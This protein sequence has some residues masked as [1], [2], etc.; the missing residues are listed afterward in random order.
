MGRSKS[1]VVGYRYFFGIHMGIGRGPVDE[2]HEVKVGERTAWRGKVSSNE[3]INIDA[4]NLFGGEE[5][6]GGVQGPLEVMM[7]G[8]DQVASPGLAAMLPGPLSGFRR[9]F[10][11]FYDGLVSMNNPYPKAWA[12]RFRRI[13]NGW[14]G[15]VFEPLY[16]AIPIGQIDYNTELLGLSL[17]EPDLAASGLFGSGYTT[18]GTADNYVDSTFRISNFGI[19]PLETVGV[20]G[21]EDLTE[22]PKATYIERI[23]EITDYSIGSSVFDPMQ[24]TSAY[25]SLMLV[26]FTASNPALGLPPA[27]ASYLRFG[28]YGGVQQWALQTVVGSG[29]LDS[30]IVLGTLPPAFTFRARINTVQRVIEH[31]INGTIIHTIEFPPN[32]GRVSNINSLLGRGLF[33]VDGNPYS[34]GYRTYR[35]LASDDEKLSGMNP[36][37]IIYECLTNR[38]W[39]RGLSRTKLDD[40]SFR[41]AAITLYSEGFGLCLKWTRKDS[42]QSF[43]QL[44]LDHI[45]ATLYQHRV[46]GLMTLKLIRSDYDPETLPF[47]DDESGLLAIDEVTVAGPGKSVNMITVKW[48]DPI[49]DQDRTVG[50]KNTA[51]VISNN[52]AVN[53]ATKEYIGVP[54]AELALRLAQR[55]LRATST[56]LRRFSLT[57][58][59]RGDIVHPGDVLMIE[60]PKR[61][62]AKMAVRVGKVRDGTLL[63]GKIRVEVMQDVFTLP[64]TS[65]SADVPVQ[66]VPP[67]TTPCADQLHAIE[68]PY[69]IL[70]SRL[71][72]ADLA[73]VSEDG[74]YMLAMA[75]K[76]KPIN[77]GVQFA[78]RDSAPTP[79]DNPPDE[80]YV[81]EL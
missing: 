71:R 66:Y 34:I 78:V 28:W 74:G 37:H 42:I 76:G 35:L 1:Q 16:A 40:A 48:H 13:L 22:Y 5:K 49:T 67:N 18:P 77:A 57:L 11:V 75:S 32:A 53:S 3:T 23:V 24:P 31:Y 15:P 56:N 55:D 63:D 20:D 2:L 4:Y 81:C 30:Q 64:S 73:F 21:N 58:D 9:M 69:F 52:G 79:D 50:Q 12:F 60:D 59:Q 19:S 47:F 29:L 25:A 17:T 14:D 45:G 41:Q 43:V 7:G 51:A 61:G 65:F 36:A 44:V 46:T 8:P 26:A 27:V 39:G 70:A 10:T 33:S 68:A 80:S 72:P 38:D 54:Y 6:E 62:I